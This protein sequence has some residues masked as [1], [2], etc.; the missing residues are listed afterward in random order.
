MPALTFAWRPWAQA[1]C[2]RASAHRARLVHA[3]GARRGSPR[4]D[5][6]GWP[7]R[8]RADPPARGSWQRPGTHV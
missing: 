4:V 6:G 7:G 8:I 2:A 1:G 3:R 5:R